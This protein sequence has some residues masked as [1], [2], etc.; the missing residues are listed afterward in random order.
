MRLND[1]VEKLP[2]I[3]RVNTV[4]VCEA[5]HS[6]LQAAVVQRQGDQLTISHVAHSDALDFTTAVAEVVAH[7]RQQG[8]VGKHA[9]LL[10]PAV[11]QSL[12]DLPIP[13]KNKLSS[14]QIAEQVRWELE[15]LLAQHYSTYSSIGRILISHGYISEEQVDDMLSQQN[16]Y[17]G[18]VDMRAAKEFSNKR[19]GEIAVGLGYIEQG[20]LNKCLA[21]QAWLLASGD[22][23][24]C[25][26]SAQGKSPYD[27]T[28]ATQYQWL[29]SAV[30]QSLLR[31]WQAAFSAQ[32]VRLEALYPLSGNAV[33]LIALDNK[34]KKHQLIIEVHDDLLTGQHLIG[35]Q[36]CQLHTLPNKPGQTLDSCNEIYQ[37][38]ANSEIDSIWLADSSSR[39]EIEAS[40][41]LKNLSQVLMQ[42]VKPVDKPAETIGAGMLGAT[43]HFMNMQG[44]SAIAGVPVEEPLPPLLQ[45]TEIR[46]ML[47]GMGLLLALGAA[48]LFLQVRHSL[49]DYENE[50]INVDLKKIETAISRLQVKADTVKKLK[51]EIKNNQEDKR[52]ISAALDLLSKDLPKRNQTV[53]GFLNELG[54]AV[55][56]DVVIDGI[57]ED[58]VF[59]FAVS[60]WALNDKSA[61]EFINL[62][63]LAVHPLGFK[64]KDITVA[65]Q[66]GRLG[67]L[68]YSIN[69]N[70]T[71]LANSAWAAAKQSP[72]QANP[73]QPS[74]VP[75][76]SAPTGSVS[77][78]PAPLSTPMES[79]S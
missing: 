8:W 57:A 63:Q 54:K 4:L 19:F 33:G 49:I 22:A 76:K 51:E 44:S 3:N 23:I 40:Q 9:L 65:S 50:K 71:T 13:P 73:W 34:S 47:A 42:P 59:G 62:F 28:G 56:Y 24:Q 74:I 36:L 29:A 32:G 15:P 20:Q 31:Q 38:L 43:R 37:L 75:V 1:L 46:A 26:W 27:E 30:N 12:I 48:E 78:D 55:S 70:A 53:H 11:L 35:Q 45:R 25:G 77:S 64:L 60:A 72:N 68:G 16:H 2:L 5:S 52:E 17:A 61:Q 41:L 67:L 39:N 21:K 58:P 14:L 66:T 6:G 18:G 79:K 10:T 69:F 7:V